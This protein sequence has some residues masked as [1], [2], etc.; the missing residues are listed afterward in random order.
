MKPKRHPMES[1][2]LSSRIPSISKITIAPLYLNAENWWL[3]MP[4]ISVD[5][6]PIY[7]TPWISG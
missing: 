3:N 7:S 4:E 6:A 1:A 5:P 2:L